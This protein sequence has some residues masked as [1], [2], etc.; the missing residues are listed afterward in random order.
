MPLGLPLT[1]SQTQRR[2]QTNIFRGTKLKLMERFSKVTYGSHYHSGSYRAVI[3]V[4]WQ[5]LLRSSFLYVY[6]LLLLFVLDPVTSTVC[7]RIWNPVKCQTDTKR[8]R[9]NAQTRTC[10]QFMF[11]GCLGN[12]NNFATK[13]SCSQACSTG[14]H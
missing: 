3:P 1:H 13:T 6:N 4:T 8:F 11:S 10:D 2:V 5:T 12:R 14:K 9:F 7:S